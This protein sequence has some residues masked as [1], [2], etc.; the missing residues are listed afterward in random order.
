[1]G[2]QDPN[3]NPNAGLDRDEAE[4]R[5]W[6]TLEHDMMGFLGVV[7]GA[8]DHLQPMTA[9]CDRDAGR[10]WFFTKKSVDLVQKAGESHAALFTIVS[11]DQEVWACIGGDLSEQTDREALERFWSP[12][13]AA[14]YERGKDD[15]E[16]T[17]LCFDLV[18]A[19]VWISER[20]PLKFAYEMAKGNL[21]R[22]TAN[23]GGKAEIGFQ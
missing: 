1:M 9:F 4:K 14:W 20:G 13:V 22:G 16:L 10:L 5:L 21:T 8:P 18:E 17:M 2:S 15:P 7:G 6:K 12:T 23:L 11:K 3:K 19:Q